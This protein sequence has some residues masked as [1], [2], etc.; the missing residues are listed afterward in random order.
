MLSTNN[1][2]M[3]INVGRSITRSQNLSANAV[4]KLGSG[5]RIERAYYDAAGISISEGMRSE[6]VQLDQNVRNA[7]TASDLLT[8]GRGATQ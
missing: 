1:N 2:L 6:L 7:E 4:A 5:H 8:G 3:A